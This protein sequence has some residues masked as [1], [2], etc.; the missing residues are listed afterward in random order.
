MSITEFRG[1]LG[2]SNNAGGWDAGEP[3]RVRCAAC[4]EPGHRY[5][6]NEGMDRFDPMA[7]INGLRGQLEDARTTVGRAMSDEAME[8]EQTI[9]V[10]LARDVAHRTLDDVAGCV[11]AAVIILA[12]LRS[13]GWEF[14]RPDEC[15]T[16]V[17][18]AWRC[19]ACGTDCRAGEP[20]PDADYDDVAYRLV[21]VPAE[22]EEG[23]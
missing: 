18:G 12:A 9:A 13:E 4:G 5:G 8:A 3:T 20:C 17:Q 1:Y 11:E 7:C 23:L 22:S 6:R 2:W 16:F 10:A 15:G 14:Y 21:P 19:N